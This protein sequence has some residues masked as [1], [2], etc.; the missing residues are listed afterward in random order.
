MGWPGRAQRDWLLEVTAHR[1]TEAFD[2]AIN[3]MPQIEEKHLGTSARELASLF[4]TSLMVRQLGTVRTRKR[5]PKALRSKALST[6]RY[7]RYQIPPK[8]HRQGTDDNYGGSATAGCGSQTAEDTRIVNRAHAS[9]LA[10]E[11]GSNLGSR[12]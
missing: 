12:R 5:L 11:L 7:K 1:E 4:E 10:T 9:R 8:R 6:L 3:F 2:R